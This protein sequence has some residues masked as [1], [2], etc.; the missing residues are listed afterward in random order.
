MQ[1]DDHIVLYFKLENGG[2]L[3]K[4]FWPKPFERKPLVAALDQ[5][6]AGI[7]TAND[8]HEAVFGG[9]SK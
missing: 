3:N 1:V 4:T 9:I 7:I 6:D 8:H 5:Q 2:T